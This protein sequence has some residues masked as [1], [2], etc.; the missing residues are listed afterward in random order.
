M[1]FYYP[2]VGDVVKQLISV[3]T[4]INYVEF[5][6]TGWKNI[7]LTLFDYVILMI[8]CI[9]LYITDKKYETLKVVC[10]KWIVEKT[11]AIKVLILIF[12]F[13]ILIFGVYGVGYNAANFIYG[14]Y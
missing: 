4:N 2:S 7:G 8:S 12:V 1:S 13:M 3:F 14:A 10:D 9:Y 6:T 11:F 5:I